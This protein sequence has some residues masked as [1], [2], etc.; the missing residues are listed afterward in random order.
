MNS[1]ACSSPWLAILIA[2]SACGEAGDGPG[3]D[4]ATEAATSASSVSATTENADTETGVGTGVGEEG[5]SGS[6]GSTSDDSTAGHGSSE[7][8]GTDT[9]DVVDDP[10][11]LIVAFPDE[12]LLRIWE[13]ADALVDDA[14]AD[15]TIALP[16]APRALAR[17]DDRLLV[18]TEGENGVVVF[19]DVWGLDDA[20]TP[21]DAIA[22]SVT[23]DAS[24]CWFDVCPFQADADGNLW[25]GSFTDV[26]VLFAGATAGSAFTG[27]AAFTH[28]WSQF[29]SSVYD[30]ASDRLFVLQISGAGIIVWEDAASHAGEAGE[31]DLTLWSPGG[32]NGQYLSLGADRLLLAGNMQLD[33]GPWEWGAGMVLFREA[34]SAGADAPFVFVGP[35]ILSHV[36][37]PV[38]ERFGAVFVG[39]ENLDSVLVFLDPDELTAETL[40]DIVIGDIDDPRQIA[41]DRDRV[42]YV[43]DGAD[44]IRIW[45]DALGEPTQR[46]QLSAPGAFTMLVVE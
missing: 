25:I 7:S 23:G 18:R 32:Y 37:A 39:S 43:R 10:A 29:G 36:T 11:E 15:H 41:I 31:H 4:A 45:D 8:S 13:D 2:T 27:S 26:R 5:S 19:D 20:S 3:A 24:Y 28:P 16:G 38:F 44:R 40:P 33:D 6:R 35:P 14:P 9:G 17:H 1:M 46:A 34:S 42:L 30:S 12:S 21:A 22:T